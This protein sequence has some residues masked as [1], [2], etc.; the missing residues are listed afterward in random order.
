MLSVSDGRHKHEGR[1]EGCHSLPGVG[2]PM[3]NRHFCFE[4]DIQL[5]R[6]G[7]WARD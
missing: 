6:Q 1:E 4:I 7:E 3:G 5:Y 2:D